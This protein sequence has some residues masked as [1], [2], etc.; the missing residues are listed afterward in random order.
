MEIEMRITDE[1]SECSPQSS[2]T[3][4][5]DNTIKLLK[6]AEE[7]FAMMKEKAMIMGMATDE[8]EFYWKF[9]RNNPGRESEY[10]TAF[11]RK[12][13]EDCHWSLLERGNREK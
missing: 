12:A 10:F 3:I 13:K 11:A 4:L 6:W 5:V 7:L 1:H 2:N 8:K 9:K